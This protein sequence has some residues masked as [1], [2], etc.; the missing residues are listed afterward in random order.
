MKI[1]AILVF[2][3]I[4]WAGCSQSKQ[5]N[6]SDSSV[7]LSGEDYAFSISLPPK[8][9]LDTTD[10]AL[11]A[12]AKA[13]LYSTEEGKENWGIVILIATKRSEGKNT[14]ANLIL[15][16]DSTLYVGTVRT[17]GP[18]L[19]TRDKKKAIVKSSKHGSGQSAAA[20]I[21]DLNV[22]VVMDQWPIDEG[23]YQTAFNIFKQV[24]ES[25]SSVIVDK[26]KKK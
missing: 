5:P 15:Y 3:L 17:D 20:Y 2:V 16:S 11:Q 26:G 19:F 25:Y 24:V 18:T 13:V 7:V 22:V 4:C 6:T 21:D 14:L 23:L 10:R 8:W 12:A 9:A 1:S